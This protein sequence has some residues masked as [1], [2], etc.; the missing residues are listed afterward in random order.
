MIE[1]LRSNFIR[2][3]RAKGLPERGDRRQARAEARAAAGGVVSRAGDGGR[4]HGLGRDRADLR[5]PGPRPLLRQGA[6]NRDYT[7]VMGVV[8]FYG[9]ADHRRS[10]CS[11]TRYGVAR[12]ARELPMSAAASDRST[13]QVVRGAACGTTP[14]R[15]CRRNR[16]A[17]VSAWILGAMAA[18]RARRPVLQPLRV[19]A[20]RIFGQHRRS[21]PSWSTGH[22]FGTDTLG[23]DLLRAHALRRPHLAAR[24]PR[25]DGGEPGDRRD[26][27]RAS[28]AT[29]AAASTRS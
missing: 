6:L 21:P 18:A 15:R 20:A 2:T 9:V 4:H 10:T 14:G 16:A 28:R 1:V 29:S 26:L 19:R 7:L 24:R 17:V 3:A 8:L 23:R 22:W 25:R 5:H 27:R 12:P 11:S 13:R